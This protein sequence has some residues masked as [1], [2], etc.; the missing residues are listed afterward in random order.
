MGFPEGFL[1]GCVDIVS[2]GTGEMRKRYGFIYVDA[3]DREPWHASPQQR[4]DHHPQLPSLG[5]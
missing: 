5:R 2:A 1:W 3:D 4:R